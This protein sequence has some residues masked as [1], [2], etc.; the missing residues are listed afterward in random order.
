[1][2]SKIAVKKHTNKLFGPEKL[3]AIKLYNFVLF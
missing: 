2:D 1:M 3:H